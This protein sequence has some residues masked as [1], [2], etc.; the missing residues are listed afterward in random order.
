[1]LGRLTSLSSLLEAAR[2]MLGELC[3]G[4]GDAAGEG[5][6]RLEQDPLW[7]TFGEGVADMLMLD[8]KHVP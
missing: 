1:M 3:V 6:G 2:F 4:S 7:H 8:L 5:G